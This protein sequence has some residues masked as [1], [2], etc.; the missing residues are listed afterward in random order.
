MLLDAGGARAAFLFPPL[1]VVAGAVTEWQ[2]RARR[3]FTGDAATP[4][5]SA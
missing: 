1:A 5:L 3:R 2:R 4:T